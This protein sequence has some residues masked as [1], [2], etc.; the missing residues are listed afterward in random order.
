MNRF[1]AL[2]LR[3]HLFLL[4]IFLTLPALGVIIYSG[5][6]Q[7]STDI[8]DAG[9]QSA[10]LAQSVASLQDD[11]VNAAEQ[12]LST[13]A[14][15]PEVRSRN[16]TATSAI[17]TGLLQK[18]PHYSNILVSDTSGSLWASA[19]PFSRPVSHWNHHYFRDTLATGNFSSG[20]YA[21]GM[22]T[23]KR[24]LHFGYPVRSSD[25]TIIG[26][27]AVALDLDAC[28]DLF[29]K[30]GFPHNTSVTL[31]DHRGTV[32]SR[33]Q[34]TK[35]VGERDKPELFAMMKNGG[36][37]G[38]FTAEGLDGTK[39]LFAYT[40]LRLNEEREPF[41]YV[42]AG[43]PE[44]E[45]VAHANGA[46]IHSLRVMA[47]FPVLGLLL[48]W[49]IGNRTIIQRVTAL[50]D[51]AQRLAAGDL[52]VRVSRTV[53]GG[54]LGSLGAAFDDMAEKLARREQD[55]QKS[56]S[57][58]A[59]LSGLLERSGQP[60]GAGTPDG[61][62]DRVNSAFA[63]LLGYCAE[64]LNGMN[65]FSGLTP[66]EW[67]SRERAALEE[68]HRTGRPVRYEKEYLHKDGSRVQ[69]EL[70]T[71][72]IRDDQGNP[73]YY[74]AF[75][76]DISLRLRME[77]ALRDSEELFRTL[78]D[79]APIGICREDRSGHN[80]YS[81]PR[82]EEIS[83]LS[84]EESLDEGWC[85][86]LHPEDRDEV[87]RLRT[88]TI[89]RGEIVSHEYRLV[90]PEGETVWVRALSN[91]IR[92]FDGEV[93]GYVGTVEDI[94]EV[95][96]ARQEMLRTDKLES[97]G[98]LAGGIAHDFNNI[99]TAIL[100]NISLAQMYHDDPEALGK[101]L[102]EAERA[103]IRAKGLTRQ[104][105][106]FARG[107]EPV[108]KIVQIRK[109]IEEAAGFATVG[110]T[111]SHEIVMAGDYWMEA[112]E[113]QLSQ[114][115]HN[116]FLN[117][118]QS[119]AQG[120]IIRIAADLQ[121]GEAGSKPFVVVTVKDNGTG[122]AEHDLPRIFDPYFTTKQQ[123]SGLGLATCYS[124]VTRHG[125][126]ITVTSQPGQGSS[127]RVTLPAL[128][129]E[130]IAAQEQAAES[131]TGRGRILVMDDERP[132]RDL[133]RAML[134]SLGYQVETVADGAAAITLYRQRYREQVPFSAVIMDLTVPAGCGGLEA[135]SALREIDPAVKGIVSSGYAEDPIMAN[136]QEHG[137]C[138]VLGK[139]YRL[140]ELCAV[141][142]V[143]LGRSEEQPFSGA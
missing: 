140:R 69:V 102:D 60:F 6:V 106:T 17:L 62:L 1:L 96:K 104:L 131:D 97:L 9:L 138:A 53:A 48:I 46:L 78:C 73:V 45:A 57:E 16:A 71:D 92:N 130:R 101:R 99:L 36:P 20:E 10:K 120:G 77:Q 14:L 83:G 115:F 105:L 137:F 132:I 122:I 80:I 58:N 22:I 100:G 31:L 63:T 124:I 93:T 8:R 5:F 116:L 84:A 29:L 103:A 41:L 109:L 117:A 52:S 68:L 19:V 142:D 88:D 107:G 24:V 42:R 128:D 75:I 70:L 7:R 44:A 114:L 33:S 25:G 34:G 72:E 135:L 127:F 87:I 26:V 15:L 79:A 74:Y 55:L 12:L 81:N 121:V 64:E 136:F 2:S 51:A 133:A 65:W 38:T 91:P 94:T 141:L 43:I 59:F 23:G 119:M 126:T 76:T 139:P 56:Q 98:V 85:R 118:V 112:D 32:M 30:T 21:T 111:V 67:I 143:V 113:G 123:G 3:T 50:Q 89:A 61:R 125:G 40:K 18:N 28:W 86:V 66:P 129:L 82:W 54:E 37:Q 108:K 110:S 13:L 90:T 27:V 134:E 39:R 35:F 47:P 11:L 4:V 95:R 49:F